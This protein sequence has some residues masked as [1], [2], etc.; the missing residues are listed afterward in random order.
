MLP[1]PLLLI[2]SLNKTET[3]YFLIRNVFFVSKGNLFD[4]YLSF[5][6]SYYIVFILVDVLNR[7]IR[8]N[9][10]SLETGASVQL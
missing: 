5:S 10:L 4:L 2:K 6:G 1:T 7:V 8:I 9:I 3:F